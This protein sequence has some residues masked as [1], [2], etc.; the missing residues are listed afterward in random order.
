MVIWETAYFPFV[1][2]TDKYFQQCAIIFCLS[3]TVSL[4]QISSS[5]F[6]FYLPPLIVVIE[7]CQDWTLLPKS[8]Y[9][10]M[11]TMPTGLYV[12]NLCIHVFEE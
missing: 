11:L 8:L 6:S 5:F 2:Y 12:R 1:I 9:S 3:F 10:T 7:A 4:R